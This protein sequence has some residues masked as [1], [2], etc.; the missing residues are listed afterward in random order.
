MLQNCA[1]KNKAP[2]KLSKS[3]GAL[4]KDKDELNKSSLSASA[5]LLDLTAPPLTNLPNNSL[6]PEDRLGW[7][8]DSD[9]IPH[10]HNFN[11]MAD[12][13][14]SLGIGMNL[15][16]KKQKSWI[17]ERLRKLF[18]RLNNDEKN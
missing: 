14:K 12:F 10:G 13:V 2:E 6:A 15:T 7:G 18:T 9:G 16:L 8:L 1:T 11:S 3:L 5:R 17:L 4:I